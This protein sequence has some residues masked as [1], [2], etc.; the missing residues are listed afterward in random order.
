MGVG[1]VADGAEKSEG[2]EPSP[3]KSTSRALLGGI[4]F[5]LIGGGIGIFFLMTSLKA[6]PAK[7]SF[8]QQKYAEVDLEVVQRDL[9]PPPGVPISNIFLCNPVLLLNS[10]IDNIEEIQAEIEKR[11]KSLRG[12][13]LQILHTKPEIYFYRPNL[14][15]RISQLLL[16]ELND[17]LGRLAGGKPLMGLLHTRQPPTLWNSSCPRTPSARRC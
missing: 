15:P 6:V 5:V 9:P 3:R 14:M 4:G 7:K 17:T 2:K 11:K 1:A 13:I 10:E 12:K 16:E 8:L